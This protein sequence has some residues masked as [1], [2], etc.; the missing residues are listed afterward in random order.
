MR[1]LAENLAVLDAIRP[2]IVGAA[3]EVNV[4]VNGDAAV[5]GEIDMADYGYPRKML[6]VIEVGTVGGGGSITIDI[7]AGNVSGAGL[8]QRVVLDEMTEPGV[9]IYEV[10]CA[11]RYYNVE[12]TGVGNDV[13]CSVL[14]I[15]EHCRY[16]SRNSDG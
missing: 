3:A 2:A 15:M 16:G 8:A 4:R 12:I 14:V 5:A 1:D 7:E 10:K 9:Q 13:T 6:I 11:Y